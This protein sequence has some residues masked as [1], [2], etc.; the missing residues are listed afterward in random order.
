MAYKKCYTC[1]CCGATYTIKEIENMG[2]YCIKDLD[3]LTVWHCNC[4]NEDT[5]F[6]NLEFK[7]MPKIEVIG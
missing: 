1:G 4:C 2:I 5:L 3:N 7:Y 6:I